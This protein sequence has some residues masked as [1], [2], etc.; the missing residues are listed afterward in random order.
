MSIV[1]FWAAV[2]RLPSIKEIDQLCASFLWS[3]PSLKSTGAK[4]AWKDVTKP[5]REGGLGIRSLKE[6]NK[7]YGLK[8]IWRFMSGNSLWGKWIEIYLLKK[9]EFLGNKS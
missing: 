6:V 4:V 5:K 2:F 1:N 8:L 9:E 3:G 7:V